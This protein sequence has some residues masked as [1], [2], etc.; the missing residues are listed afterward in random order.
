M[1]WSRTMRTVLIAGVSLL[2]LASLASLA[3]TMP[4]SSPQ[5]ARLERLTPILVVDSIEPVV[6]F[7]EALGFRATIPNRVD[8]ELTFIAFVK[9]GYD[10]HYQ[11]LARVERDIPGAT[12]MLTGNTTLLYLAV[13][14]LDAVIAAL[15]NAEVVIP[16]RT[17]PWGADEIYVKEPGGNLIGFAKYGRD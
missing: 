1:P 7:W 12:E 16:R 15:G 11:T 17:T 4:V 14:D 6:P 2:S 10:I 5:E 8:G 13:D 3:A 9:E